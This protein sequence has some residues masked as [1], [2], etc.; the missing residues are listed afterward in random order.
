MRRQ[1]DQAAHMMFN[2]TLFYQ[3]VRK[4]A[5]P[6]MPSSPKVVGQVRA[7]LADAETRAG[8]LQAYTSSIGQDPVT[9]WHYVEVKTGQSQ[10]IDACQVFTGP[11]VSDSL[12][13]PQRAVF[14]ACL[15][16]FGDT[17]CQLSGSLW[18]PQSTNEVPVAKM[19]G[20]VLS[21]G[22]GINRIVQLKYSG[23]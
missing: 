9:Y 15:D 2:R 8:C 16:A 4:A 18:T 20:V 12:T 22:E 3:T 1:W 6:E 14:R 13:P 5:Y 17:N 11:A 23:V 10:F 19:H 7:C 21:S